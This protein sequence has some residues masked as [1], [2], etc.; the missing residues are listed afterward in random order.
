MSHGRMKKTDAALKAE[1]DAW[2]A[3]AEAADAED[4]ARF[5]EARGEA[6][7]EW[8]MDE[9]Q[10]LEKIRQAKAAL[11]AEAKAEGRGAGRLRQAAPQGR[12]PARVAARDARGQGASRTFGD[13]ES[14]IMKGK[15][16]FIQGYTARAAAD[17]R[18]QVVVAH[19]LTETAADA[20]Q[21]IPMADAVEANTGAKPAELSR[22]ARAASR[23]PVACA[24]KPSSPCSVSSST[25]EASDSSSCEAWPRLPANGL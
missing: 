3:A 16:G 15:D 24:S 25:P 4:D 8:M 9:A 20:G 1:V 6:M 11:E 14:R 19:G 12:A 22:G 17:A 5:G 2:L 23:A 18:A 21:P 13:P 7:P 10:R